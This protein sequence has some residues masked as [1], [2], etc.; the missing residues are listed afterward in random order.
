MKKTFLILTS[1]LCSLPI[2]AQQT[3]DSKQMVGITPMMYDQ[4]KLPPDAKSA[5]T[6]KLRQLA[7][8]NGF[9]SMSQDFVITADVVTVDKQRTTTAP[10]QFI[11]ELQVSIYVVNA[12][13]KVI[14]NETSMG[15]KG[16]GAYDSKAIINA[17]NQIN[18]K[19]PEMRSFM[20]QSRT[21]IVD[22]YVTMTPSIMKK[23]SSLAESGRYDEAL[24]A[25]SSVPTCIDQYPA[26]ADMLK[27]VYLKKLDSQAQSAI[28]KANAEIALG[29]YSKAIEA[30]VAIDPLSPQSSQVSGMISKI[31]SK[32]SAAQ[33]AAAD[34]KL[35]EY[36]VKKAQLS[37]S[38]SEADLSKSIVESAAK[39]AQAKANTATAAMLAVGSWLFF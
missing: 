4:V 8:Q 39:V 15:V 35:K 34:L 32:L 7:T 25:L 16:I 3:L 22:Y 38:K 37:A 9:G 26:V 5:M 2:F 13:E 28:N 17:I 29:N 23:A 33:K 6:L 11:V 18:A 24:R 12:L 30:M 19:T 31:E 1:L 27:D 20:N 21:K 14:I 36:E 10:V